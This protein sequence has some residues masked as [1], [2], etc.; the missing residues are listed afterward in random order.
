[1]LNPE[2]HKTYHLEHKEHCN[3]RRKKYYYEHVDYERE[4][5][6]IYRINHKDQIK[7]YN[8]SIGRQSQNLRRF[9]G[10][11]KENYN[12]IMEAQNNKCAIC[13]KSAPFPGKSKRLYV[14]HCHATNSVRGLLCL[15][16]NIMLGHSK[17]DINI[18][19]NAIKYLKIFI[20]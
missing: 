1:M 11:S 2:M 6:R 19:E 5:S 13:Q 3:A 18:L 17:D 12:T 15:N 16:C 14:D 8:S 9:H 10:L 4:R 20:Q 7:K